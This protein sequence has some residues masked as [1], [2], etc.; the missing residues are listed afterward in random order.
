MPYANP[1]EDYQVAAHSDYFQLAVTVISS[2]LGLPPLYFQ[3]IV[4]DK[5]IT[6]RM[7]V[8]GYNSERFLLP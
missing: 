4:S 2:N 7:N 1:E 8:I 6:L 5:A 3:C